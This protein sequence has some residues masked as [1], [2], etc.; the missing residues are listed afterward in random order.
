MLR[1][2][3]PIARHHQVAVITLI[4]RRGGQV[5]F[6]ELVEEGLFQTAFIQEAHGVLVMQMLECGEWGFTIAPQHLSESS[7]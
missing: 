5:T 1:P 6:T 7:H 4:L 2:I 3:I